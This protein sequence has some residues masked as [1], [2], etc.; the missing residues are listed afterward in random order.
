MPRHTLNTVFVFV[1]PF[2]VILS[3][4]MRLF[5]KKINDKHNYTQYQEP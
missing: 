1:Y 2:L 4:L 5:K 3:A